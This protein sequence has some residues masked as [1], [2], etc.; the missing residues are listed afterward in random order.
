MKFLTAL[1]NAL[2]VTAEKPAFWL[3]LP[4]VFAFDAAIAGNVAPVLQKGNDMIFSIQTILISFGLGVTT[5]ALMWAGYKMI[6]QKHQWGE[7]WHIV[8]GS[9]FIGGATTLAGIFYPTGNGGL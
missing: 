4:F 3:A 7:I 8:L 2:Q 1:K 9:L 5:C 6:V